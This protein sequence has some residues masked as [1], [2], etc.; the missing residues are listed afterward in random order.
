[1]LTDRRTDM[2]KLIVAFRNF[3]KKLKNGKERRLRAEYTTRMGENRRY[4]QN[5]NRIN[6]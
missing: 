5:V 2:M 4:P 1:M 3:A 6:L